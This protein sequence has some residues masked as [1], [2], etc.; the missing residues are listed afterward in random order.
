VRSRPA[1]GLFWGAFREAFIVRAALVVVTA[2]YRVAL[3]CS[4]PIHASSCCSHRYD[5]RR[6]PIQFYLGRLGPQAW[7]LVRVAPHFFGKSRTAFA[8][9]S[10]DDAKLNEPVAEQSC[11]SLRFCFL[12]PP[13]ANRSMRRGSG[14][15]PPRR[16]GNS[17]LASVT[18]KDVQGDTADAPD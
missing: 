8:G 13:A 10:I 11:A 14:V 9:H 2:A 18:R 3:I 1:A 12:T 17:R 7:F 4:C 6:Q 15:W 16:A 5:L